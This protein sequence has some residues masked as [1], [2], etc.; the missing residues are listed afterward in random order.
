MYNYKKEGLC[1]YAVMD[2][3]N[4]YATPPPHHTSA[5]HGS[6]VPGDLV[7]IGVCG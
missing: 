6:R 3:V 5:I 2:T 7:S 4:P 1:A